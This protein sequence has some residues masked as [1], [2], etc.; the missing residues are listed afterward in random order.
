MVFFLF[1]RNFREMTPKGDQSWK[2]V[3]FVKSGKLPNIWEISRENR[4]TSLSYSC[5]VYKI[6]LFH[7]QKNLKQIS[8]IHQN[9]KTDEKAFLFNESVNS[10]HTWN[11]LHPIDL[12]SFSKH[13]M[14]EIN[15][16]HFWWTTYLIS[17]ESMQSTTFFSWKESL[18]QGVE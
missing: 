13:E 3:K 2:F 5:H 4:E 15:N 6:P 9:N 1:S 12:L 17:T 8:K 14:D 10:K 11:G 16:F 7:S 18:E